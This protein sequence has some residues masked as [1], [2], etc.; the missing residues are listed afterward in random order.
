ML[1]RF[2]AKGLNLTKLESRPKPGEPFEYMFYLDFL[3]NARDRASLD[4]ICALSEELPDFSYL[5]SSTISDQR[6]TS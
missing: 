2:A 6:A 3:G 1:R 4:L 5:G